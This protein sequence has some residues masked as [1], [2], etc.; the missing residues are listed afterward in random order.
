M[1]WVAYFKTNDNRFMVINPFVVYDQKQ[2]AVQDEARLDLN[3]TYSCVCRSLHT[4][5]VNDDNKKC[6]IWPEC[7]LDTEFV[8]YIQHDNRRY[9][10]THISFIVF[11][12]IS[13]ILSVIAIPFSIQT[14]KQIPTR[15]DVED[16]ERL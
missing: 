13:V 11:S 7:V 1:K 8:K 3:V 12:A 9:K 14:I 4:N 16:F 10:I 6:Q 2:S 5:N 15:D